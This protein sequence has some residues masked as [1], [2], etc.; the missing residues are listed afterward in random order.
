MADIPEV[1]IF[2]VL[3]GKV[4]LITGGAQGMGKAT[5]ETFVKAGA[6]VVIADVKEEQGRQVAQDLSQ[7]GQII[8]VKTDISKSADVQRLLAEA[9]AKFGQVDVAINNAALTPDKTPLTDFDEE[10]QQRT[11]PVLHCQHCFNQC[12][13]SSAQHARVYP[14]KAC[15]PGSHQACSH[16]RRSSRDQSKCNCTGG[17]LCKDLLTPSP[18]LSL[19]SL[20]SE[21]SAAALEIMGTTHDEFA[22]QVSY[23]RRFGHGHEVAQGSCGYFSR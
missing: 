12:L 19:M 11:W 3:K 21:M 16:G 17:N 9:V 22:P 4:A 7:F 18:M 1:E 14:R 10:G 6:K 15:Y 13:P 23:L 5:A 2:P 8:F 20:Q